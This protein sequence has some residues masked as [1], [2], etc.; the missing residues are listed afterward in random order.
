MRTI[1]LLPLA[2]LAACAVHADEEV[3]MNAADDAELGDALA[4]KT[5][6]EPVSCVSIRH[7][8]GSRAYGRN[9]IL[10]N[11]PGDTVYLNRT[12]SACPA[13]RPSHATRV[14]TT[15]TQ[16]C[17]GEPIFVFDPQDGVEYGSCPLGEFVPYRR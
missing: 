11:G 10:F 3:V 7:L 2:A 17:S 12:R 1:F 14:R 9:V 4:G 8:G 13:M 6:G 5:A 15:G 16:I